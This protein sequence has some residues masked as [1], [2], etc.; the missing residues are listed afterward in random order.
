MARNANQRI[1]DQIIRLEWLVSENAKGPKR[2]QH[3]VR[4]VEAKRLEISTLRTALTMHIAL[5]EGPEFAENTEA[6]DDFL[7]ERQN[8]RYRE[9][10]FRACAK[11]GKERPIGKLTMVTGG[12]VCFVREDGMQVLRCD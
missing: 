2:L 1:A 11:C 3:G 10:H 9:T 8:E 7:T 12:G 4:W 5:P 6:V